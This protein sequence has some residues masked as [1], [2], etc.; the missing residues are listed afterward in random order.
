[1]GWMPLFV[2]LTR[3]GISS[4]FNLVWIANSVVFPTLFTG[5]AMGICNVFA[6]CATFF[7]PMLAEFPAP[8]PMVIFAILSSF[9]LVASFFLKQET[10]S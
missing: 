10:R 5:T 1:M 9:G 8:Y 6:R 4:A 7:S 2:L 3:Y